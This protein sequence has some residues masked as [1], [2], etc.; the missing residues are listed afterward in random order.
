MSP[1]KRKSESVSHIGALMKGILYGL[2][3]F[4]PGIIVLQY[5]DTFDRIYSGIANMPVITEISRDFQTGVSIAGELFLDQSIQFYRTDQVQVGP[6]GPANPQSYRQSPYAWTRPAIEAKL[7]QEFGQKKVGRSKNYLNYI[8]Q[9]Q[10]LAVSEMYATRIPASITIAQ[11]L[12]ESRAG[13]SVL[14]IEARNHFGIKCRKRRGSKKDGKIDRSDYYHHPLAYDCM[15]RKDDHA[16]DHFEMYESVER[17]FRHHSLLLADSKRYNW[18]LDE[19]FTGENYK[20]K[21]KWF[22]VESVPY[23]AAW[24]IGL[25]KSG[26]ATSKRYAQKLALIIETYELWRIDYSVVMSANG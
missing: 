15:N 2:A 21:K 23:Y 8:E 7:A 16:W 19:Y 10:D 9:Y 4:L 20:V 14:A 24:S 3:F 6:E 11:G 22:G 17:S 12:L 13:K 1:K 25:K 18:M 5:W 26:Y